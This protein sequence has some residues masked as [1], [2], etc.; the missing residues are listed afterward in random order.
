M[1]HYQQ[2]DQLKVTD[3]IDC[4]QDLW[5]MGNPGAIAYIN[6]L[7]D[8]INFRKSNGGFKTCIDILD[9]VEILPSKT[10]KSLSKKIHAEWKT[11]LDV[12]YL[13]KLG[14]WS[15][16]DEMQS[17]LPNHQPRF[18]QM[19]L[20]MEAMTSGPTICPSVLTSSSHAVSQ[21]QGNTADD[22]PAA[23]CRNGPS[24]KRERGLG[25]WGVSWTGASTKQASATDLS[26]A[27]RAT[28]PGR[29][30][31]IHPTRASP[32]QEQQRASVTRH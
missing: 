27:I 16:L 18:T 14:F 6:A 7:S 22:L 28:A 23:Y 26:P 31:P 4:L 17:V 1:G 20:K 21:R 11:T 13:N 30:A 2:C 19:M 29:A 25:G 15:S 32:L 10:R 8:A 9:L 12:D 3:F 24:D 5:Q